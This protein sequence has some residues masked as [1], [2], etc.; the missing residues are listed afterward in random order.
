[1][2]RRHLLGAGLVLAVAGMG[3]Y[4]GRP[5]GEL[6]YGDL[7]RL[8]LAIALANQPKLLLMDEPTAGM[9]QNPTRHPEVRAFSASLEG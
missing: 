8:E 1:M 5:C 9:R 2:R 7:K 4:A 3:A 6:A